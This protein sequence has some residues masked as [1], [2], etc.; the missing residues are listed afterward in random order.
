MVAPACEDPNSFK[1][2]ELKL[3]KSNCLAKCFPGLAHRSWC[4]CGQGGPAS[5]LSW[6]QRVAALFTWYR[7]WKMQDWGVM[8]S[9]WGRHCVEGQSPQ[10]QPLRVCWVKWWG[11]SLSYNR[12]LRIMEMTRPWN[13]CLAKLWI[14]S[15]FRPG[16]NLCV[17]QATEMERWAC[18]S[19]LEPC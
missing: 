10:R 6:Q 12:E 9:S 4:S 2:R 16:D 3:L 7:F 14:W 13:G 11:W 17:L 5:T 1:C 8:M 19:I 18:L 15:G